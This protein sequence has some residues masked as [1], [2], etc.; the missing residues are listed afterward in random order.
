MTRLL[1]PCMRGAI[2]DWVTYTCLMKLEDIGS[3]IKFADDI[4][5]NK[6]L[7]RMI[8]RELKKD[9]QKSIGEYLLNDSEAFFNAIVVAIYDGEPKWH[10]F[11]SIKPNDTELNNVEISDYAKESM[12]YLSLTKEEKIFALDGQHRL[13]G[14]KYALEKD[15]DIGTQQIPVIFLPHYNDDVGLKRTR[16][17]FTTLNKKAKPVNKAAIIA[18]DEDD[19]SAC[20]T[21]YLVENTDMFSG[22]KIKFQANNNIAYADIQ[23]ITTI[24]NLYDLCKILC[25]D[26]LKIPTKEIDN[27]NGDEDKKLKILT[28]IESIFEYMFDNIAPLQEFQLSENRSETVKKF[29]NKNTGGYFLYRP[30]G[31]KIYLMSMCQSVGKFENIE[32][33]VNKCE[34]FIE[35]TKDMPLWL[36]AEPLKNI[37]WDENNKTIINF[38][39]VERDKIIEA[40]KEYNIT[41]KQS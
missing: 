30:V 15:P 23:Q 5:K 32:T 8:Q 29:R 26:G 36:E 31:L 35:N 9:R 17:L 7:S 20:A 24:G 3:L 10:P 40:I 22:D 38:K 1:L 2:G 37:V 11:D 33:F 25:K 21:R 41:N 27:Y 4:H 19:L 18:L 16:R 28:A 34:E 39:A 6:K 14:I 12:G 13:S